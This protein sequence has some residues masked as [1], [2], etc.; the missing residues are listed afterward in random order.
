MR[1][2]HKI[3]FNKHRKNKELQVNRVI[4]NKKVKTLRISNR[5]VDSL[6][7]SR[8]YSSEND[9]IKRN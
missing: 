2:P 4:N 5:R 9:I 7:H 6:V 1:N 3:H 8:I